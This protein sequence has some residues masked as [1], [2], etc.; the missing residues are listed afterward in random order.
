[1]PFP[2]NPVR[3]SK[4]FT[5]TSQASP[6]SLTFD[7]PV[8]A[9]STIVI[10]GTAIASTDQAAL[11]GNP[12]GAGTFER[13]DNVRASGDFAPNVFGAV[14]RNV[15]AGS[16]TLSVPFTVN[17][18]AA[19]N[20]RFSGVIMEI[21]GAATAATVVDTTASPRTGTATGTTSTA[22]TAATGT[23]SQADSLIVLTGGGWGGV[24]GTPSTYTSRMPQSNGTFIGSS[25]STLKVAAT[26]SLSLSVPH[27]ADS[28]TAVLG[29][30]I[31]GSPAASFK[32]VFEFPAS[33]TDSLP[34]SEGSIE[35]LVWRNVEPFSAN[36]TPEYYSG[37]TADS[38]TKPGD[39]TTRLLQITTGLP[40]GVALSDT[41]RGTFRKSG[42]TTKGSVA[43]IVGTVQSA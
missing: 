34:S 27:T 24:W 18:A 38:G 32:Y 36:R 37:L 23:L 41:L 31:K 5:L 39:T 15:A 42:G 40:S 22:T 2:T 13:S 1:M 3:Q 19:T 35:A 16:P 14:L 29:Y 9:G 6:L 21:E 10:T 17:G 43:V 30:V 8:I 26:T 7:S 12:S 20:F 11:I 25:V 33:G 28:A 4:Q